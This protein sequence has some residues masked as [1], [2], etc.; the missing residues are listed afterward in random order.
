MRRSS[1]EFHSIMYVSIQLFNHFISEDT[2]EYIHRQ[3][4]TEHT[5][6]YQNTKQKEANVIYWASV[7]LLE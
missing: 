7:T 2:S 5:Q 4:K 3:I 6:G 1:T